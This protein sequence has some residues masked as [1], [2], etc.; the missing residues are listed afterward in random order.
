MNHLN[1]SGDI[2]IQAS[3]E[4]ALK[5]SY[6][7]KNH[8]SFTAPRT[9]HESFEYLKISDPFA[10]N[11][12]QQ[13]Q[14]QLGKTTKDKRVSYISIGDLDTV[15]RKL[16]FDS[17]PVETENSEQKSEPVVRHKNP[18]GLARIDLQSI[19]KMR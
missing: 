7:Q 12:A 2:G 8:I 6:S 15:K 3:F 19:R 9:N 14:V 4:P 16:V 10:C 1:F 11:T 17:I 18:K 5:Q 13:F